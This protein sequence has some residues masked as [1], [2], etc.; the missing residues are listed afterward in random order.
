MK[1]FFREYGQGQPLLVLHGLFGLSD[2]WAT[3]AKSMSSNFRVILPDLRNHGQS[4]HSPVF[5]YPSMTMDILELA[6]DLG[7]QEFILL[8]HSL[9]GK[10]AMGLA[11]DYPERL[12][13]LV[14]V[15]ISP[16]KYPPNMEHLQILNA[17]LS[18]DLSIAT[19]RSDVES[20]LKPKIGSDR[21]R[22]LLLKNIC[23]SDRNRLG[24]RLNLK[25]IGDNLPLVMGGIESNNI[26]EKPALFIRGG[27]SA[28]IK[29]EDTESILQLFP[30]AVIKTIASAGHWVH[31]DAFGEFLAVVAD[32]L[33]VPFHIDG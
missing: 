11:L 15:D 30:A 26:Y 10:I 33:S 4:P 7:L 22:Q 8:G 27:R 1:L 25:S 31:A 14:I 5:D 16:R 13:K 20:Q 24:W 29:D 3:F 18:V 21:T 19:K 6:E 23:W 28:Y 12:K 2:N 17:M 32:F 9:G